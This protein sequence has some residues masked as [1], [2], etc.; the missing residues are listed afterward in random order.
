MSVLFYYYHSTI[1]RARVSLSQGAFG[2]PLLQIKIESS[3]SLIK[4]HKNKTLNRIFSEC[5][6]PNVHVCVPKSPNSKYIGRR[7]VLEN[8]M[9]AVQRKERFP[10]SLS[11]D[12]QIL[13]K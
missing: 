2:E 12:P 4:I 10:D 7:F 11:T 13:V 1:Y 8:S 5:L 3:D 9:K 6:F